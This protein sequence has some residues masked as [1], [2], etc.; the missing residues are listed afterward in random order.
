[1]D[2][3]GRVVSA[4]GLSAVDVDTASV[5]YVHP[6]YAS[7]TATTSRRPDTAIASRSARSLASEPEL[8]RNTV[9][10]GSGSVA[11]SRSLNSTTAA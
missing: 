7:P 5:A 4:L 1:M 3:V 6:W 11:A 10:S 8:T 2:P 9:S